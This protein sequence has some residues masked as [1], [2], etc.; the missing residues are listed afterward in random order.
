M[1]CVRYPWC[2][3]PFHTSPDGFKFFLSENNVLLCAGDHTGL[4]PP[5]Y[6]ISVVD[7]KS[8]N[9]NNNNRVV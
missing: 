5:R 8:G 1:E 3:E 2:Y 9:N 6:F 7:R 4:L